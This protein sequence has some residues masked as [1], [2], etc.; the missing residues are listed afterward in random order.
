MAQTPI[1]SDVFHPFD[2]Q[3]SP[4]P[5]FQ[6]MRTTFTHSTN[7]KKMPSHVSVH[8]SSKMI[9]KKCRIS[10][11]ISTIMLATTT[12][13]THSRHIG[14]FYVWFFSSSSKCKPKDRTNSFLKSLHLLGHNFPS[15]K[16]NC[17]DFPYTTHTHT[18]THTSSNS[19]ESLSFLLFAFCLKKIQLPIFFIQF[20]ARNRICTRN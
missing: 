10:P 20:W 15:V 3:I 1:L 14:H 12:S 2:L 7:R 18:H 13:L 5:T 16:S 9:P 4:Y 19:N 17:F 8:S 11:S 6:K